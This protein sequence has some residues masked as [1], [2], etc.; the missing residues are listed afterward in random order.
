LCRWKRLPGRLWLRGFLLLPQSCQ[1]FQ[2][3]IFAFFHSRD[4]GKHGHRKQQYYY[5]NC[6]L[7]SAQ[8]LQKRSGDF[9]FAAASAAGVFGAGKQFK[10][11]FFH[12]FPLSPAE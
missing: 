8:V 9:R 3:R 11:F 2:Y 12:I 1:A 6:L 5:Q 10:L 4:E 7:I